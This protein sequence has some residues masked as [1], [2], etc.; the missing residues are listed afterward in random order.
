MTGSLPGDADTLPENPDIADAEV[1]TPGD[2]LTPEAEKA[3]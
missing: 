2:E 1:L 3:E